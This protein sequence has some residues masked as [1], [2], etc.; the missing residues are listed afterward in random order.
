MFRPSQIFVL[1]LLLAALPTAVFA[2][3]ATA[4]APAPALAKAWPH[5]LSDLKGDSNVHWGRLDNG[6]RY[7]ILPNAEPPGRASLRLYVDAGSVMEED[8]QQGMAHFLEHMA[9]NGTR[10]FPAGEMIEYFQRLGMAFGAD[11]NAHT[12][13]KETVYKLE[14]P[15][16]DSDLLETSCKLLSDY[17]DGM[18]LEATEIDKER[19]IILSEKLS[20]DSVGY[21]TL[22]EGYK[23]S[24]PDSK[25]SKRIPIGTEETI[26]AMPR[27]RFVDFYSKWY[28]PGRMNVVVVGD[29]D[30]PQI[31]ELIRTH[32]GRLETRP[33]APEPDLGIVTEGRGVVAKVHHED[34]MPYTRI[35]V[36]VARPY[37]PKKDDAQARFEDLQWGLA[38]RILNRRFQILAKKENSPILQVRV[39]HG[40]FL[41][42][43][44]G[45]EMNIT[46][47]ADRWEEAL[48]LA[49]QELRR[50]L[51]FGFT[52]AELKEAEAKVLNS[53]KLAAKGAAT[54]K[55]KELS[56]G[57]V[58]AL[59]TGKVF[60]HPADDLPRVEA[61]LKKID[62]AM[63]LAKFQDGW[64]SSDLTIFVGGNAI[65]DGG[66]DK[67]V[68][69]YE[70]SRGM[71]VAPPVEE[72]VA[73]FA[74]TDFGEPS[75]IVGYSIEGDI[76]VTQVAFANGVRLNIKPTDFKENSIGVTAQIGAGQL[77]EPTDKPGLA[78]FTSAVLTPGGLGQHS[79][80]E[81]VA[82][83]AGRTV[84]TS[85]GVDD[86][87]F[88]LSGGTTPDD[89]ELQLQLMCA[90][91][92]DPGYRDEAA[93]QF[94]KSLE[95]MYTQLAHTM[96]GVMQNQVQ[97]YI[98]GGDPRFGYPEQAELES[99]SLEEVRQWMAE[100][101]AKSYLELTLVGDL[102]VDKT[103][104]LVARTFGALPQRNMEKTVP[105]DRRNIQ[106]PAPGSKEFTF[107]S[108]IPKAAVF[109]Y[110]PTADIWD[111]KRSRRLGLLGDVF[112]DRLRKKVREELGESY[113][114]GAY[115]VPSD[116][117]KDYGYLVAMVTLKPEQAA[118]VGEILLEI[119][120]DLATG[121][122]ADDEFARARA[123]RL[124]RLDQL[125]RDNSYWMSSVLQNAQEHPQRLDWARDILPDYESVTKEELEAFAKEY[126][127]R[128]RAIIVGVAPE[129]M[130][131]E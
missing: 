86:G 24:L 48:A 70:A 92:T 106:F 45:P 109:A 8:D 117:Y 110:W 81:L 73:D 33:T 54:R 72:D 17:A 113:S 36:E 84:G 16:V 119:G 125:R 83:T 130:A 124:A 66:A 15:K 95:P 65:V 85:F 39:S 80:D 89:L 53:Y 61:A 75:E 18:L 50:A 26:K 96:E 3:A 57:M 44:E 40:D 55:S 19:G 79:A 11:T 104:D 102:D 12:S 46:C 128:D 123:P 77:I 116:V 5:E 131:A 38:E 52:E 76:D 6:L 27:E 42:F 68:A 32:F 99:R 56:S 20:R 122:I 101:L 37:E 34:E 49:E 120:N 28:T 90:Y 82:I 31:E 30:I 69:V 47:K 108:A 41:D 114:P 35:S 2:Q 97:S 58:R 87:S 1:S 51:Q 21:R 25:I 94:K 100:P 107:S 4:T 14:L 63:C 103:I 67:V 64:R 93:R 118:K 112:A 105:E 22:V 74:Y 98:H 10:D 23:F 78:T 71:A 129:A 7:A 59:A 127:G 121:A 43:V 91:L 88:A 115:H 62:A 13:F 29:I 9:F 111:I 60:T 126:L